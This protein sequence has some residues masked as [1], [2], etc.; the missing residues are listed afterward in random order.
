[1]AKE[2]GDNIEKTV[3]ILMQL[4]EKSLLLI[5]SGAKL[6]AARQNMDKEAE[7]SSKQLV[8]V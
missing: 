1:M 4:D 2:R 3:Q 5:D 8:G 6:L 7:D